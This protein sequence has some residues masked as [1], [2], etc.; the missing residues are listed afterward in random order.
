MEAWVLKSDLPVTARVPWRVVFPTTLRVEPRV[1]APLMDAVPPTSNEVLVSPPALMPSLVLPV[2]SKLLDT[3]TPV[4]K[5][6]RAL[7][8]GAP[9]KVQA[10]EMV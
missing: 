9:V 2:S 6:E 4:L 3:D 1:R 5:V 8:M 7:K 10:P